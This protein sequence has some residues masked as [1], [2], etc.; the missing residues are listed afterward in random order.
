[1]TNG[2]D[3][4]V[5]VTAVTEVRATASRPASATRVTPARKHWVAVKPRHGHPGVVAAEAALPTLEPPTG[6][7]LEARPSDEREEADDDDRPDSPD[8]RALHPRTRALRITRVR[9]NGKS[10]WSVD[11]LVR[12]RDAN[13]PRA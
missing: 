9:T 4:W 10:R 5:A 1:V 7:M 3:V 2:R 11:F 8:A 13:Q 6:E 12:Q